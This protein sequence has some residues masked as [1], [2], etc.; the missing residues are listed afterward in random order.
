MA[1][2]WSDIAPLRVGLHVGA[3]VSTAAMAYIDLCHDFDEERERIFDYHPTL[4]A[5]AVMLFLTEGL[6]TS[7]GFRHL[8]GD[9]R[10]AAIWRHACWT[11]PGNLLMIAGVVAMYGF[12][13]K[14]RLGHFDTPHSW[15]GLAC[16]GLSLCSTLGG[17]LS[18]HRIGLLDRL[19]VKV[20]P[21]VK[22]AHRNAGA[23]AWL[24]GV[25]AMEVALMYPRM[26]MQAVSAGILIGAI[27]ATAMLLILISRIMAA[28]A[29]A[30]PAPA[31]AT[32]GAA[33]AGAAAVTPAEPPKAQPEA[34]KKM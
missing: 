25:V 23:V 32:A 3:V 6:I 2:L 30:A 34:K 33:K 1:S 24:C 31:A 10:V 13:S 21:W 28:P 8:T 12:K 5:T 26:R 17:L 4:M 19:P 7:I 18:F 27:A 15:L 11:A 29:A 9:A 16:L 22:A 14:W 20:R